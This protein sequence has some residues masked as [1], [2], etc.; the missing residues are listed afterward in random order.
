M[1]LINKYTKLCSHI[2]SMSI[3]VRLLI[4]QFMLIGLVAV[5]NSCFRVLMYYIFQTTTKLL[6]ALPAGAE[7]NFLW[8][9]QNT[10]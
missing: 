5:L 2:A 1:I 6:A 3:N 10:E 8:N 7:T 4:K 9:S